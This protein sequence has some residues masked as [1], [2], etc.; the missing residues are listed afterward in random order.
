[1]T[2]ELSKLPT[3]TPIIVGA[4]Q[5]VERDAGSTSHVGMAAPAA[6]MAVKDT[7]AQG[8][9]DSID[10]I[11]MIRLFS[12]I[13]P[14]WQANLGRSNNP[15]ESIA[16]AIGAKPRHRI[17]SQAGG[18]EPQAL[19]MEFFADIA[20]GD[21]DMVLLAGAE[22]LRNQRKAEKQGLALDWA[23][24]YDEP[25][26][27]RGIGNIFPDPQELANGMVMPLH[28]YTLIEQARRTAMG[29]DRQG[30]MAESA[31]LMASFSEIASHNPYSQ[32]PGA[33]SADDILQADLLTHLYTKR[34]IAQDSVNQG[35]AL[36]LTSVGKARELGIPE[37][38][39][40]FMHGAAEGTDVD[41]SV[42]PTLGGS[43]V[44]GHV[45]D[46]ALAM[47]G[48]SH[49]S[50]DMFDIYSCFPCAVTAISDHLHLPADGSLP[51]TLT[52]GLPFFGGPG[53]N[54]SMHGL[55]ETVWQLRKAPGKFALVHA[56]GGFLTKHATG[57]F[58]GTASTV[59]WS[60]AN[61]KIGSE[62]A[63]KCERA[64]QPDSGIVVSYSIN[65]RGGAVTDVTALAETPSG[66]RFVCSSAP[67]DQVTV[68][69]SLNEELVGKSISVQP[70]E[71]DHS[72]HYTL[73]T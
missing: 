43:V 57:I 70:G 28:Y 34:M 46:T 8:I 56:N 13:A 6:A 73:S 27:D 51:L 39:W 35:A 23:E 66:Q 5:S 50:I 2:V 31:R 18:N 25:L 53:N 30:Y 54:Y 63:P 14:A 9:A 60:A 20:R 47:A 42:R 4:G 37:D 65:F 68:Q 55:A 12:D 26:E 15:P 38:N 17:Y 49:N 44:A 32:W 36:L 59:D 16:R 40:I 29:Q 10:T 45:L 61:T 69:Q 19:L 48:R 7:G 11:A 21:R 58:S 24:D 22:A 67:T 3:N 64:T 33:Q 52:G 41:V 71:Q 72:L 62:F 1:M